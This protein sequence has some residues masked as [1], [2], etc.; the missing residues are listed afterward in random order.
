VVQEALTNVL[1]HARARTVSVL[2]ER[3]D[4]GLRLIVEDDG[5]GF[6]PDAAPGDA[7]PHLGLSGMRERLQLVG[8]S[9]EVESA[10]G[11]GTTLF[12]TVPDRLP[13]PAV[14]AP[15]TFPTAFS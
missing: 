3:R 12:M 7:R 14:V 11:S 1:K 2:L 13:G 4:D 15:A 8:G 9:L 10:P 5:D 6:D